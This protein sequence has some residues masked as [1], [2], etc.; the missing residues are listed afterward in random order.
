MVAP[1]MFPR[2]RGLVLIAGVLG[3]VPLTLLTGCQK[4]EKP[5]V[6]ATSDESWFRQ[7]AQEC[8]GDFSKLSPEDQKKAIALVGPNAAEGIKRQYLPTP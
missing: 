7:K 1:L 5:P 2:I 3:F 8:K 4:G 6:T